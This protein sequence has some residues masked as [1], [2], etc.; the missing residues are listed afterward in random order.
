MDRYCVFTSGV[1]PLFRPNFYHNLLETPFL[2]KNPHGWQ[3]KPRL[4]E[5]KEKKI[6]VDI[7]PKREA[8]SRVEVGS[9][10]TGE[11]AA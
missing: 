8:D 2:L 5:K 1:T 11:R 4:K 9:L 6:A 3:I 10:H 7:S